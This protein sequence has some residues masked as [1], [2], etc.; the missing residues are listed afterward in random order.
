MRCK[1]IVMLICFS[2]ALI[3]ITTTGLAFEK[4]PLDVGEFAQKA[5]KYTKDVQKGRSSVQSIAEYGSAAGN[6]D[7]AGFRAFLEQRWPM[8]RAVMFGAGNFSSAASAANEYADIYNE[9]SKNTRRAVTGEESS[10]SDADAAEISLIKK[11]ISGYSTAVSEMGSSSGISSTNTMLGASTKVGWMLLI[12]C[13]MVNVAYIGYEFLI[14][15]KSL[16]AGTTEHAGAIAIRVI[17]SGLA[18]IFFPR[19]AAWLLSMSDSLRDAVSGGTTQEMSLG[20]AYAALVEVKTLMTGVSPEANLNSVVSSGSDF[21]SGVS[22]RLMALAQQAMIFIVILSV[23][24]MTAMTIVA[25]PIVFAISILPSWSAFLSNWVKGFLTLLLTNMLIPIYILLF[26]IFCVA[27]PDPSSTTF[28]ITGIAFMMLALKL[29]AIA[30]SMGGGQ[31]SSVATSIAMLPVH[32]GLALGRLSIA[33][34]GGAVGAVAGGLM[35]LAGGPAGLL[36]GMVSGA[37]TGAGVGDAIGGAMEKG[38]GAMVNHTGE[39]AKGNEGA[40]GERRKQSSKKKK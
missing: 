3:A 21:L 39:A 28:I 16:S 20:D 6:E 10:F 30:Q 5:V 38:M 4:K 31:L 19:F 7:G 29:P 11:R 17:V 1:N 13:A 34:T 15:K 33:A 18:L 23:D 9:M 25:G 40:Q 22:V 37:R 26:Y 2:A 36:G 14:E 32:G 12:L 24:I 27:S 35:G 8:T